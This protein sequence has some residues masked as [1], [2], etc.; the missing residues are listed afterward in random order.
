VGEW[1]RRNSQGVD[2]GGRPLVKLRVRWKHDRETEAF[3]RAVHVGFVAKSESEV[4]AF[5]YTAMVAGAIDNGKPDV[6]P[7]YDPSVT[8][9]TSSIPTATGLE[10]VHKS[11]QNLQP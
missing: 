10:V 2:G 7:Y 3:K 4:N 8:Q 6:R 1:G 11:W 9:Q 5:Y